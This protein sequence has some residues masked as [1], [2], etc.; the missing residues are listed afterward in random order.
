MS[1]V[2]AEHAG[3]R[4]RPAPAT[5]PSATAAA[6]RRWQ[7]DHRQPRCPPA[8]SPSAPPFLPGTF[9]RLSTSLGHPLQTAR[10]V[11]GIR[12]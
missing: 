12:L 2:A 8:S 4:W 5:P 10:Q 7:A 1:R 3:A 9:S 11:C 6:A